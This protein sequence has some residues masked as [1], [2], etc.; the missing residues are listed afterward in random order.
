MFMV[1]QLDYEQKALQAEQNVS[2]G[3]LQTQSG[4]FPAHISAPFL[5]MQL[6]QL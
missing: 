5:N 4:S 1:D 2:E 3:Q 6:P